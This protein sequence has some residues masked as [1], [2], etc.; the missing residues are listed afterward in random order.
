MGGGWTWEKDSVNQ[1]IHRSH[2]PVFHFPLIFLLLSFVL[3]QHQF[4]MRL[5]WRLLQWPLPFSVFHTCQ[6][7]HFVPWLSHSRMTCKLYISGL[8]HLLCEVSVFFPIWF[9][10]HSWE[11]IYSSCPHMIVSRMHMWILTCLV[12]VDSPGFISMAV[13]SL[14]FEVC[15]DI[16]IYNDI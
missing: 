12:V 14:S 13:K 8:L 5:S 11:E 9:W 2:L 7:N 16:Y 3:F 1:L 6:V 10:A 4:W 15:N